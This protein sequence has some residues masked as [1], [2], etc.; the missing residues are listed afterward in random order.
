MI[1]KKQKNITEEEK[2]KYKAFFESETDIFIFEKLTRTRDIIKRC[3]LPE[4]IELRKKLRYNHADIMVPEETSTAEKIIKLF[5][6]ENNLLNKK[7]K[8]RK[9]YIWLTNHNLTIKVDE[10]NHENYESK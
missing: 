6:N 9:P 2:E 1:A 7:F 10:G 5:P 8:N 3:K 4:T